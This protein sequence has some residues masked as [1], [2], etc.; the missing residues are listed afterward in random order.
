MNYF[1]SSCGAENLRL[2]SHDGSISYC[3]DCLLENEISLK[4]TA[5]KNLL[6]WNIFIVKDAKKSIWWHPKLPN[7]DI[8]FV[9]CNRERLTSW[10]DLELECWLKFPKILELT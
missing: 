8:V 1:C 9:N 2:W 7:G 6:E 5:F 3:A 10:L 4:M